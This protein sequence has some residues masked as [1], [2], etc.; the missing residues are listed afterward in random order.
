MR[1]VESGCAINSL[2][3]SVLKDE[4]HES[5]SSLSWRAISDSWKSHLFIVAESKVRRL[6]LTPDPKTK[7]LI[8]IH[9]PVFYWILVLLAHPFLTLKS[10]RQ[11]WNCILTRFAP[12]PSLRFRM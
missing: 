6:A 3:T 2:F 10:S 8:V 5:E 4:F 12:F 9:R 1:V 7:P 11:P